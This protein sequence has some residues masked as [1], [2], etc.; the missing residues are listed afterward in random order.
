MMGRTRGGRPRCWTRSRRRTCRRRSSCSGE[1]VEEH[2][3]LL[4]RIAR[5]GARRRGAWVRAPAAPRTH[6]RGRSKRTWT[7]RS[8]CSR[9]TASSRR[10]GGFR[11]GIWRTSRPSSRGSAAARRSSGGTRTRMTGAGTVRDEMLEAAR[12]RTR[13][14]RARA[15][16]RRRRGAARDRE[17]RPRS[18]SAPLVERARATGPRTGA[19]D[20]GLAGSDPGR[21]SRV[22]SRGSAGGVTAVAVRDVLEEIA[23]NAAALDAQPAFPHA[24]F[25]ALRAG[26]RAHAAADARRGV[27]ASSATSPRPTGRSGGSSRAT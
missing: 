26:G 27:G 3:E 1:R 14:D 9:G 2:P 5:R 6:A 15:R 20:A 25:A 18:S 21:E 10:G 22:P 24:A 4:E 13:R 11:G 17:E 8:R 19:A 7:G 12:A 16:R 23:A